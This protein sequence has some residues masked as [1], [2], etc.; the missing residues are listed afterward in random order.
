M[1]TLYTEPVLKVNTFLFSKK[2]KKMS[3][4]N[5]VV[6]L[7]QHENLTVLLSFAGRTFLNFLSVK[8]KTL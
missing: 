3:M 4:L 5:V 7:E 1:K 2:A 6:N 8:R